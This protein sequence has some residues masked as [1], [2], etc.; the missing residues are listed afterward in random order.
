MRFV[1]AGTTKALPMNPKRNESSKPNSS[2]CDKEPGL[3]TGATA[4]KG[5]GETVPGLVDDKQRASKECSRVQ[6]CN[7]TPHDQ[8]RHFSEPAPCNEVRYISQ[9]I[10]EQIGQSQVV[11][12]GHTLP[13]LFLGVD[14]LQPHV[15]MSRPARYN[16]M[17]RATNHQSDL[18]PSD[19]L[20]RRDGS[21][22]T[23][24]RPTFDDKFQSY[25]N[26][27]CQAE[28]AS[29]L[30]FL[31]SHKA[32][33]GGTLSSSDHIRV[34]SLSTPSDTAA[35]TA[36]Q[37]SS[38][39]ETAV[40]LPP[41]TRPPRSLKSAP[42]TDETSARYFDATRSVAD[43]LREEY[44]RSDLVL[45]NAKRLLSTSP[46]KRRD[47]DIRSSKYL[48]LPSASKSKSRSLPSQYHRT[49]QSA[50]VAR[51]RYA[52]S[53]PLYVPLPSPRSEDVMSQESFVQLPPKLNSRASYVS[54]LNV[55]STDVGEAWKSMRHQEADPYLGNFPADREVRDFHNLT[56]PS[57]RI[58]TTLL[59]RS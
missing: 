23:R 12:N 36:D 20:G 14:Q 1:F 10:D 31:H 38:S 3:T 33:S 19:A 56:L 49:S 8:Q 28:S 59:S 42:S 52:A 57:Q 16:T 34:H 30:G 17:L 7:S 18:L 27:A 48:D 24:T 55:V 9:N 32:R 44:R 45:C 46:L 29:K 39:T 53:D 43:R 15:S 13:N 11:D 54:P 21:S 26:D 51:Q 47:R 6:Y 37:S 4:E 41:R 35:H 5:G 58:T 2:A 22:A 50:D 40:Y 25:V